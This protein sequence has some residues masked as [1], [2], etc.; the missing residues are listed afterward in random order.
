MQRTSD[1]ASFQ[2]MRTGSI[3]MRFRHFSNK[4]TRIINRITRKA[5]GKKWQTNGKQTAKPLFTGSNPVA[6]SSFPGFRPFPARELL[7]NNRERV[8][9]SSVRTFTFSPH[10]RDTNRKENRMWKIISFIISSEYRRLTVY[11][12]WLATILGLHLSRY[13]R[14]VLWINKGLFSPATDRRV[15]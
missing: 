1:R 10:I 9:I 4:I 3:P 11:R 15:G 8:A 12:W 6:A 2:T 5:L 13:P 14:M 7:E